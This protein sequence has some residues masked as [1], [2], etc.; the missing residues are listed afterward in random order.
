MT[1]QSIRPAVAGDA[2]GISVLVARAYSKWIAVIGRPP[3]PMLADYREAI[4]KHLVYVID[5][6]GSGSV[7]A[8]IELA[9]IPDHM[10]VENV[11]VDPVQQ[12]KGLGR[13]LLGYAEMVARERGLAEMRLYTNAL[14]RSNIELYRRL[15]YAIIEHRRIDKL[16]TTVVYMSKMLA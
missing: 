11:A 3:K 2:E 15:G 13:H 16:D 12:G 6:A 5:G 8:I 4:A 9:P 7:A 10:L 1:T 14:M